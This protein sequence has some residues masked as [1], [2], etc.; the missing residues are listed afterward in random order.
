VLRRVWVWC[1]VLAFYQVWVWC[2]A[3]ASYQAP[4]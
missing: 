4:A 1:R 3:S 2:R